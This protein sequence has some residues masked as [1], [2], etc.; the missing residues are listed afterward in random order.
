MIRRQLT[1]EQWARIA[2]LVPGKLSDSGRTGKDTR[3]L[4]DAVLWIARTGSP[5]AAIRPTPWYTVYTRFWRWSRRGVWLSLFNA[6]VEDPDFEYLI[7]DSTI[8]RAHQHSAGAKG[9]LKIRPS[10]E[11]AAA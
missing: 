10:D 5:W 4:L 1:D 8:V 11:V 2:D 7:I 3:L 9:G 6:L